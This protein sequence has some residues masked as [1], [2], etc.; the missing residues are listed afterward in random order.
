MAKLSSDQIL[1]IDTYLE[2]SDI[3][4][5]DV[6]MEMVD[7]VAS[8]I[9]GEMVDGDDR[10]FYDIFKDYMVLNKVKLL[11]Q[12]KGFLNQ[13]D[14]SILRQIIKNLLTLRYSVFFVILFYSLLRVFN[15]FGFK[16]FKEEVLYY[17]MLIMIGFT[18]I[19]ISVIGIFKLHRYAI[20]SRL[21]MG[22]IILF[23]ASNSMQS[24]LRLI[25]SNENRLLVSIGIL[26][27][28]FLFLIGLLQTTFQIHKKY[29]QRFKILSKSW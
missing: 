26:S 29:N 17:P 11:K 7:H 5:V 25:L 2:N 4:Y 3:Q 16:D 27:C 1:F 6:R 21:S 22:Y 13:A 15:Y 8:A 19:Y 9:E 23:Y 12:N 18:L 28:F 10:S 20:V 14:K 24:F